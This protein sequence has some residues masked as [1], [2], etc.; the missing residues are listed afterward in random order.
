MTDNPVE[1]TNF[2]VDAFHR[3]DFWLVQP[4]DVGHRAGTD[5]MML[6]AGVPSDFAGRLADLGAGAGAAGLAVASRCPQAHVVLVER[7]PAMVACAVHTLAEPR[8]AHLRPRASVLQ[9]DVMLPGRARVEAGLTDNGFDFAILNP[10]FN[11]RSH[12]D[13]PDALKREAHVMEADLFGQWLRTA[14]AI[15]RPG[16]GLAVIARPQSLP[17]LLGALKG[18]FGGAE[19]VPIHPRADMPAIRI[20]LRARRGARAALKLLPALVLHGSSG[21][22]FG[23][24]ADAINNGRASL[25]GD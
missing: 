3:G 10:P 8:N 2:T 7:S 11:D 19:I 16:G 5:A 18:R 22:S 14:A 1:P 24:R 25:F 23:E 13:S 21:H 15:V 17:P 9:A 20:V 12:R 6:A 4:K